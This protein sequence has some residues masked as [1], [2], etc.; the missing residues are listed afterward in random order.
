MVIYG[1]ACINSLYPKAARLEAA[2]L[3]LERIVWFCRH[4]AG[5]S[6]SVLHLRSGLPQPA[7]MGYAP[8][9]E[10]RDNTTSH[11]QQHLEASGHQPLE[12]QVVQLDRIRRY[13]LV[14][15]EPFEVKAAL[16]EPRL[17]AH[18]AETR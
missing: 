7:S 5:H 11:L 13:G 1:F 10:K 6:D 17:N 3:I 8:G 14:C 12:S 9:F 18:G 15:A 16:L 4:Q 2:G